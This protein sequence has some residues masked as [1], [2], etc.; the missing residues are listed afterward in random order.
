[1][2]LL[3]PD[4]ARKVLPG[5][6]D[7]VRRNQPGAITCNDRWW[8]SFFSDPEKLRDGYSAR[9]YAVHE[10]EGG[11]ADGCAAYR[12]SWG[13]WSPERPGSTLR[14]QHLYGTDAEVEAALFEFLLGVDLVWQLELVARPV[15]DQLRWRLSDFRRYQVKRTNDWLW[16]RLLDIPP[17]LSARRYAIDDSITIGVTDDFRPDN[18]GTYRL[19]SGPDG[20]MCERVDAADADLQLTVD[21]L[22]AMYLGGASVATLAAAGRVSGSPEAVARADLMFRSRPE[23]FCDLEF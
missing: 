10:N 23:P 12:M 3:D 6:Y 20:A 7:R 15:E 19:E 22:G 8:E 2:R 16:L 13:N 17:A 4:G 18:T 21:V 9:Y 11:E 14:L 5:V 1:M